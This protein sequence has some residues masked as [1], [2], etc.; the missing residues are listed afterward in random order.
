MDPLDNVGSFLKA[1][2]QGKARKKQLIDRSTAF[3]LDDLSTYAMPPEAAIALD[4]TVEHYG[5]EALK[6]CAV[7]AI[8]KW[9]NIHQDLLQQHIDHG[10]TAEA[11]MTTA[12]MT[13]LVQALR[14]IEEVG[15]FGGDEDYRKAMKQQINQAILETLEEDGRDPE[16]VFGNNGETFNDNAFGDPL[17]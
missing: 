5:D 6:Q 17:P 16:E 7:V 13:K 12:D 8:G 9:I 1:V 10:N 4:K 2:E 14:M 3:F 11:S 15:S